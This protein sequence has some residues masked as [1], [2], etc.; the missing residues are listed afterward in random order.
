MNDDAMPD[1]V[2]RLANGAEPYLDRHHVAAAERLTK[3]FE[4]ARLRQRV[5]MSYDPTR[6]GRA[7][8]NNGP[9]DLADS[10]AD[11]RARL[12]RLAGLVAQD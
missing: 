3:L 11:A 4:R 7:A 5:T 12:N 9:G 1:A 6:V 2:R 8:G 10:T